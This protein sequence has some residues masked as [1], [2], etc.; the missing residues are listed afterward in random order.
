MYTSCRNANCKPAIAMRREVPPERIRKNVSWQSAELNRDRCSRP[1]TAMLDY[2]V[3]AFFLLPSSVINNL[4][5]H[6][7][8]T[9]CL[10]FVL[11]SIIHR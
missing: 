4:R 11:T 7:E 1:T 8:L 5:A 10:A 9:I 6:W 3:T 2:T